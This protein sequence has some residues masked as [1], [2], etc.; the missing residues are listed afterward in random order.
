MNENLQTLNDLRTSLI[1]EKQNEFQKNVP[2]LKTLL[3][4]N[5]G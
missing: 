5:R 4:I 2:N 3:A 1:T